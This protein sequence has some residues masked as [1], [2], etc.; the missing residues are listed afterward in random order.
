M[1]LSD[2]LLVVLIA[3]NL[4]GGV[5]LRQWINSLRGTVEAQKTA[6][7]TVQRIVDAA[8][9]VFKASDPERWEGGCS[10]QGAGRQESRG[11]R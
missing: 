3:V 7:D 11:Y 1:T 9:S 5:L 4:V 6:L 8:M 10:S 2:V